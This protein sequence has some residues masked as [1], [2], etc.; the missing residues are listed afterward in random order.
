MMDDQ[1]KLATS[2][3]VDLLHY[4]HAM[5][6]GFYLCLGVVA[7]S[8]GVALLLPKGY[9]LTAI[10][11][12]FQVILVGA[13]TFLALQN[14][15][16]SHSRVRV[17]W[18][19]IF[20]G[21]FLWLASLVVWSAYEV[22]CARPVPDV[23]L[24]DALLFVKLVPFTAAILLEP[25]RTHDSRFRAFGFLDVSILMLYSLY[26]YTFGVFA[27]RLV[28]G[29]TD[30]Y[31][32]RFNVADAIGNQL[33]TLMAAS[34]LFRTKGPWRGIYRIY[35][36]AAACYCLASNL[37]NVA[38]D[39]GRYYTGSFYDVPLVAAMA[40][41][42]YLTVAGRSV[43]MGQPSEP[44]PENRR[45]E[46]PSRPTFLSSHLAMLVTISTP[47]IGLWLLSSN[48]SPAELFP[49]RMATTLLTI[50]LLTLLLS[51]KQDLLTAGLIGSLSRLSET[52]TSINRFKSHL[53]QTEKLASSSRAA[54]WCSIGRWTTVFI[55][56][57]VFLTRPSFCHWSAS[58]SLPLS[59]HP[60]I[61]RKMQL[62]TAS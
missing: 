23:P 53:L 24:V 16:R 40:A 47:L 56:P 42:V 1:R 13:A 45:E 34:A 18:L 37:G 17:F 55:M 46:E 14:F 58:Y 5:R 7:I 57:A 30:S 3:A 61:L 48:S 38:I 59:G 32:L 44:L 8:L 9:A 28:P 41:F 27:Y 54:I 35:F 39:T 36:F 4:P 51:I 21:A 29:G 50:F 31:N 49:F 22:W 10:G 19:L 52:F 11:D 6:A 43:E 15:F 60:L 62:Q 25:H 26:L 2:P 20:V 33:F 12:A